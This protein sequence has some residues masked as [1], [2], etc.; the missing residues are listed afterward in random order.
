MTS[1]YCF[2][3][4]TL[5]AVTTHL[6]FSEASC[7]VWASVR[8]KEHLKTIADNGK[9][10]SHLGLPKQNHSR[11]PS[12]ESQQTPIKDAPYEE[13]FSQSQTIRKQKNKTIQ[14]NEQTKNIRY[15]DLQSV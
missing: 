1:E 15:W 14:T 11:L 13:T 12:K 3:E 7:I 6:L 5:L 2:N 10:K 9:T 8:L 4:L